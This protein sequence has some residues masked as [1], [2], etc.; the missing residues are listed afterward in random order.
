MDF[1]LQVDNLTKVYGRQR[2][3]D[4]ASF[5][6][7]PGRIV[8]LLG[9]NGSGKSTT[10]HCITGYHRLSS[11]GITIAGHPHDTAA[12]K[13]RLGFLPDDLPLPESLSGRELLMLH[14]H[15]RPGL[16][17]AAAYDLFDVFD[18]AEHLDKYVGDY[19]HGMKRKLQ[20]VLAT[21]HR[22]RLL[23][24]DEPLRGLDP[25]AAILMNTVIE[26]T[27]G[28]GN[29]VLI[30]THDLF[31]AERGCDEVVIVSEGRVVTQ[32]APAEL[33]ERHRAANLE[34]LFLALT[35]IGTGLERKL[36]HLTHTLD[37]DRIDPVATEVSGG[38][39]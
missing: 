38:I 36:Q 23:V 10:L 35:G 25:E 31:A 1:P 28:A 6:V 8:G 12:A 4:G 30:A 5:T 2:G 19:S 18:L 22:P 34:A 29:G 27:A 37:P 14:A 26:R 7:R 3:I 33:L 32:G 9:P 39:S 21:A 24:L 20:L 13:N 17:L 16:D 11:G 15:L